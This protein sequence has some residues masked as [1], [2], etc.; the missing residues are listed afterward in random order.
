V[1]NRENKAKQKQAIFN[2]AIDTAQAIIVIAKS[3]ETF[4]Y[5]FV[6]L[7]LLVG[8]N[9]ISSKSKYLSTSMVQ[10]TMQGV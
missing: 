8:S 1:A 5:L 2:I 7:L 6:L 3:P 9:W 10:I 4:D